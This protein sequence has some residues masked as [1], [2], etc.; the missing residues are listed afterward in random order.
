[1][2]QSV[3]EANVVPIGRR[4]GALEPAGTK[5]DLP[6]SYLTPPSRGTKNGRIGYITAAFLG[7]P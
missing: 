1:M 5:S 2:H 6:N 3:E 7:V 4:V